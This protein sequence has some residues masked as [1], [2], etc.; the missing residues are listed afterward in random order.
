[1]KQLIQDTEIKQIKKRERNP[2]LEEF[3]KKLKKSMEKDI[4]K[5]VD[6]SP[7]KMPGNRFGKKKGT[8]YEPWKGVSDL[9]NRIR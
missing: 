7:Y 2:E 8:Y 1:M 3:M 5:V 9:K 4:D 6:E